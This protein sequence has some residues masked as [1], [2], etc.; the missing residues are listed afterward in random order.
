MEDFM[1]NP[2]NFFAYNEL[3]SFGLSTIPGHLKSK[4]VFPNYIVFR[5][6]DYPV[7]FPNL[8]AA[9]TLIMAVET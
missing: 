7:I 1:S 3:D 9:S 2:F 6:F 5:Y 4:W 8:L